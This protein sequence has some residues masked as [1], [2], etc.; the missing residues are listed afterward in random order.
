MP[1]VQKV[2]VPPK[3]VEKHEYDE[4]LGEGGEEED[5]QN[6]QHT[7]SHHEEFLHPNMIHEEEDKMTVYR[8]SQFSKS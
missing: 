7:T 6:K 2:L 3:E 1:L 5:N 4:N 8:K